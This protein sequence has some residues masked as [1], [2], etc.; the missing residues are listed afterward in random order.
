MEF[1]RKR[2]ILLGHCEAVGRDPSEI[3][4]S[5]QIALPAD[6][7]PAQSV[8]RAEEV[9][10]TPEQEIR[11]LLEQYRQAYETK[12]LDL[13]G[14]I[15]AELT[16]QQL[17]AR[18]KYFDSTQDLEVEINKVQ[19][20]VRGEEAVVSYTREDQFTDSRTGK[21]VKLDVRLTK[22]L[23]RVDGTWKMARRKK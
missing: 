1:Q 2:A 3:R 22:M 6:E 12:N 10:P 21:K 5:V 11:E 7:P 13:L 4:C 19:I 14:S 9:Q 20:A 15:Y 18:Q 16:P 23:R 17:Q 8:A